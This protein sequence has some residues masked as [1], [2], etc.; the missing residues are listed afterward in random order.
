M[1]DALLVFAAAFFIIL[2]LCFLFYL[3]WNIF[4]IFSLCPFQLMINPFKSIKKL[5]TPIFIAEGE[6]L[7]KRYGYTRF[8]PFHLEY[9]DE[10]NE[11]T[12]RYIW[13]RMAHPIPINLIITFY[14]WIIYKLKYGSELP[15][16][17]YRSNIFVV[18]TRCPLCETELHTPSNP[19]V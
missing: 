8:V 19:S 6:K 18:S 7:R 17:C 4:T 15:P 2:L 3:W 10:L 13:R 12:G 14:F 9:K 11:K 16:S 5:W 1:K